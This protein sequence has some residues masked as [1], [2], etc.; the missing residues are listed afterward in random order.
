MALN[1]ILGRGGRL[2]GALALAA[3]GYCGTGT[4]SAADL[5][6]TVET[7]RSGLDTAMRDSA[8]MPRVGFLDIH[9]TYD[10]PKVVDGKLSSLILPDTLALFKEHGTSTRRIN[11][12]RMQEELVPKYAIAPHTETDWNDA[13]GK[14]DILKSY[15]LA[16]IMAKEK[17]TSPWPYRLMAALEL[18][19]AQR[20]NGTGDENRW[21]DKKASSMQALQHIVMF[22]KRYDESPGETTM[23]L[24]EQHPSQGVASRLSKEYVAPLALVHEM[25]ASLARI[26]YTVGDHRSAKRYLAAALRID[27]RDP[28]GIQDWF[29]IEDKEQALI[30]EAKLR[31]KKFEE[32]LTRQYSTQSRR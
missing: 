2:A 8:V 27:P 11:F 1:D 7:A 31:E 18:N 3:V 30:K 5:R 10:A 9:V 13:M 24:I 14:N 29:A 4:A 21:Y 16:S 32:D 17:S 23:I 15:A 22:A 26:S 28:H 25:N 12:E 6:N 20:W 19:F